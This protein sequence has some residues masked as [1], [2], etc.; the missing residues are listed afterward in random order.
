MPKTNFK[1]IDAYHETF[2]GEILER[3][4]TIRRLIHE[5]VPE[6]SEV[7]SYQIPAFKTTGGSFFIYYCAFQRHLTLSSPWSQA[8]V[9][10]FEKELAVLKVSRAAI[11]FRHDKPLPVDLIKRILLFRK[12]EIPEN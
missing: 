1:N 10:A 2:S 12:S 3:L 5:T 11:Q 8:F 9:K 7:I 4:N 6:L